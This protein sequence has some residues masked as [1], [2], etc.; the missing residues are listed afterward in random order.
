MTPTDWERLGRHY[1]ERTAHWHR[2]RARFTDK[3]PN[4]WQYIGAIRAMLPGARTIVCRRDPLETCLAC[5]RQLFARHE[6]TRTF[7]DLAAYW[8]DF[9]RATRHWLKL[10]PDRVYE[11]VYE[12]LVADPEKRIRDL[13]T[14]CGLE[15]EPG[16]VEFHKTEREVHSPSA[17]QVREP[18]RRDTARAPRYG[19]Q[20]DRLRAALR[21]PPFAG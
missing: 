2:H 13:L 19:A 14:F 10:Y 15:F 11:N 20:L 7:D 4:N 17:T 12:D 18:I 5:Y 3:L 1:L 16:C 9:D 8:R 6:Y 21:M